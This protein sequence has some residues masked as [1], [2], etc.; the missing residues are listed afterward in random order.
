MIRDLKSQKRINLTEI[1]APGMKDYRELG[2]I[3]Y[4]GGVADNVEDSKN[5]RKHNR[6]PLVARIFFHDSANF[7]EGV[8]RYLNW[9]NASFSC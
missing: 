3:P 6:A 1:F 7:F 5:Q 9:G 2:Q 4:F 8:C